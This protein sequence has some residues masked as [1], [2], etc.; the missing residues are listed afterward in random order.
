MYFKVFDKDKSYIIRPK[1]HIGDYVWT[2]SVSDN[3]IPPHIK[4]FDLYD[5][6]E[7]S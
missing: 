7:I 2:I 1:Y 5:I 4:E 3:D 6:R